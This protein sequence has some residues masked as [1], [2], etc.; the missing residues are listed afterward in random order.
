MSKNLLNKLKASKLPFLEDFLLFLTTNNYSLVTIKNYERDLM[1][2]EEF[3]TTNQIYFQNINKQTITIYKADLLANDRKSLVKLNQ[4]KSLTPKSINRMLTSLRSYL[5]YLI[6]NDYQ[7]PILPQQIKL[8]KLGKQ[9]LH[10]PEIEKLIELIESPLK[11]E[12]NIFIGYRNKTILELIFA[13]G[14]RI[15]EVINLKMDQLEGDR[16]KLL[17]KGKGNKERFVYLTPRSIQILREYLDLRNNFIKEKLPES[18]QKDNIISKFQ[19]VFITKKS[20]EFFNNNHNSK[21][22][23]QKLITSSLLNLHISSNYLQAKI[24]TYRLL[25][26]LT[27]KVSAHTLRHGFA[28]YLAESGANPSALKVLLGH[29]SLETTT[30]YVHASDKFAL[31]THTKYHPLKK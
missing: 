17:I 7:V 18:Y 13:S 12:K 26:G 24:K 16:S 20:L 2:F 28:T 10:L 31:D 25:L 8:M 3:L 27:T 9:I 30:K 5:T 15:S 22:F 21:D 1:I 23:D 14:M 6:D 4:S 29:E 19:Y 11:Y